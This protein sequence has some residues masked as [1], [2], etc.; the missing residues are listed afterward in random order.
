M[1]GAFRALYCFAVVVAAQRHRHVANLARDFAFCVSEINVR[2]AFRTV[3]F[4]PEETAGEA[5]A[6]VFAAAGADALDERIRPIA[7]FLEHRASLVLMERSEFRFA[8]LLP[9]PRSSSPSTR[10]APRP[11]PRS[12]RGLSPDRDHGV[13][14]LD[15][16]PAPRSVFDV[17]L[18][19]Y[20]EEIRR[21]AA[22]AGGA[23]VVVEASRRR[24]RALARRA[25]RPLPHLDAVLILN[26]ARRPDRWRAMRDKLAAA[27]FGGD[28][29]RVDAVDG[30][31]L[32]VSDAAVA[33]IFN[34]TRWR[35]GAGARNAHQDHGYRPRVIGCALSHLAAWKAVAAAADDHAM[36]LVLEDDAVFVDDFSAQWASLAPHLAADYSW[37]L[38]HLGVLDDRD[39]YDDA[40]LAEYGGVKRFSA[41]QRSYGAGAFAYVL[42][43][44][45]ARWLLDAARDRGI[46]Q[47]VDWWIVEKFDELRQQRVLRPGPAA[48]RRGAGAADFAASLAPRPGD[49]VPAGAALEVRAELAVVGDAKNFFL[50]HQLMRVCYRLR[51][52]VAGAGADAAGPDCVGVG[53]ANQFRLPGS[54]LAAP[55]WYA[56]NATIAD[57]AG[58]VLASAAVAFEA[59]DPA[60]PEAFTM[61][62]PL[63]RA[64]SAALVPVEISVDGAAAAVDCRGRPD[65]FACVQA[66]CELHRIEPL[67]DCVAPLVA[68]LHAQ[69]AV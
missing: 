50:R 28:V 22:C 24:A 46:Q 12:G 21:E 33:S 31:A 56:L 69:V 6:R 38:V 67:V 29:R 4:A 62:P 52:L 7:A 20:A 37:D 43:P 65:L 11:T 51:R 55:A 35:Y 16:G 48:P 42:R 13:D 68:T 5:A 30:A 25:A 10:R 34:L 63:S 47:A 66:F 1:M 64:A 45:T 19:A 54:A 59:R 36:H 2:D 58:A 27:G 17:E 57:D 23:P 32:D 49:R 44:R 61:P 8:A 15:D 9:A 14:A 18:P 3:K 26:L 41:R 40:P 60:A 39:L 53:K